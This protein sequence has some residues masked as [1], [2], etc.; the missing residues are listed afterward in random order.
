MNTKHCLRK[1]RALFGFVLLAG[2]AVIVLEY[3][4]LPVMKGYFKDFPML[5]RIPLGLLM[6]AYIFA[7]IKFAGKTSGAHFNPAVTW[8]FYFLKKISLVNAVL[9]TLAQFIGAL[10]AAMLL[11]F[12]L[13][14][15]FGDDAIKF[16]ATVPK[17][18]HGHMGAFAAEFIISFLLML[19]TLFISSSKKHSKK[20]ALIS[21][22]LIALYL[23]FEMPFSGMSLNP[24]R[25]FAGD[26]AGKEWE[27]LWLYFAAPLSAM[28][29]AAFIFSRT[30]AG[31]RNVDPGDDRF[32]TIP[33]YPGR[34]IILFTP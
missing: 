34:K 21:G 4:G 18:P 31:R 32:K 33:V 12:T 30:E 14:Q 17:P 11:K 23:V 8:S 6:G 26:F 3:P 20:I 27:H 19:I 13:P 16:G 24:A 1:P 10:A 22:V 7:G 5:R 25:S 28:L 15:Y 9:Y 2:L 29:L